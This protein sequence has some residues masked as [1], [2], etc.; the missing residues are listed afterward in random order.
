MARGATR[1]TGTRNT[2]GSG[3]KLTGR[4]EIK[5]FQQDQADPYYD[6]KYDNPYQRESTPVNEDPKRKA[7]RERQQRIDEKNWDSLTQRK[8]QEDFNLD[9]TGSVG[10]SHEIADIGDS[11]ISFT[12]GIDFLPGPDFKYKDG[13]AT[14]GMGIGLNRVT[15]VSGGLVV[16]LATREVVGISGGLAVAGV[17]IEF[18]TEKCHTTV[19]IT[20]MGVGITYGKNTCKEEEKKKEPPPPRQEVPPPPV[21]SP[22]G[23]STSTQTNGADSPLNLPKEIPSDEYGYFCFGLTSSYTTI[24]LDGSRR[25]SYGHVNPWGVGLVEKDILIL[26]HRSWYLKTGPGINESTNSISEFKHIDDR[27]RNM[28]NRILNPQPLFSWNTANPVVA[29]EPPIFLSTK[30]IIEA[31]WGLSTVSMGGGGDST[32]GFSTAW[33]WFFTFLYFCPIPIP[34]KIKYYT[35]PTI[36]PERNKPEMCDLSPVM[37]LQRKANEMIAKNMEVISQS[38]AAIGVGAF[39]ATYPGSLTTNKG[40]KKVN[41][42]AEQVDTVYETIDELLGKYPQK[43]KVKRKNKD[44]KDEELDIEIPN[45]SEGQAELIGMMMQSLQQT[46][47]SNNMENRQLQEL[48]LTR[49][50]VVKLYYMIESI[51]EYLDYP[52]ETTVVNLPMSITPM[53]RK[54]NKIEKLKEFGDMVKESVQP[55]IV[56]KKKSGDP[57][58]LKKYLL[59]LT[60]G[61][62]IIKAAFWRKLS[63]EN[64]KEQINAN[65]AKQEKL[66][67]LSSTEKAWNE[68]LEAMAGKLDPENEAEAKKNSPKINVEKGK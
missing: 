18:S 22:S 38:A 32:S 57:E 10:F 51:M 31:S 44:G 28:A 20:L 56:T 14:V 24:L 61:A 6:P 67:E 3:N 34:K 62:A 30:T 1:T 46:S 65:L 29:H 53:K 64:P 21:P 26:R 41:N 42:L 60:H 55:V 54:G 45:Q 17:G 19:T 8:K 49:Q 47:N 16:D 52:T 2:I 66:S 40:T 63:P 68:A 7:D 50:M 39:P 37:S 36:T 58:T 4:N 9:L 27:G 11:S 35:P 13:K 23:E 59:H 15:S 48:A 5:P 43:H 12:A 33:S 25:I